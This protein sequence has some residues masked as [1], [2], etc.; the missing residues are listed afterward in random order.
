[1]KKVVLSKLIK[2]ATAAVTPPWRP[3]NAQY[4]ALAG[5]DAASVG[6]QSGVIAVWH[7]GVRPAWLRIAGGADLSA[8]VRAAQADGDLRAAEAHGGVY[9]A[10]APVAPPA[11][12]GAVASLTVQL[13]LGKAAPPD[14]TA[15]FPLPPGSRVPAKMGGTGER[16]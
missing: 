3:L 15:P 4:P 9:L 6:G 16:S 2:A 12:A 14:G 8:L 5:F 10:W 11:V 1:M 7:L 13:G